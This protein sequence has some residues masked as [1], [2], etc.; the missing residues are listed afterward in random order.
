MRRYSDG[1][2]SHSVKWGE[3]HKL[4]FPLPCAKQS[5]GYAS[6]QNS[7]R[8]FST[9]PVAQPLTSLPARP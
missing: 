6:V 5:V 7:L 9:Y 4:T 1:A 2:L 3:M 8:E